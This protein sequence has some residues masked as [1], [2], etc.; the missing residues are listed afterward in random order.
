[1]AAGDGFY[2]G[3][4]LGPSTVDPGC[5]SCDTGDTGY[6]VY[7]GMALR[8]TSLGDLAVELGYIDFGH[9][10]AGGLLGSESKVDAS[11]LT[12]AAALRYHFTP[13]FG[14]VGRLGLGYV[15]GKETL[16]APLIGNSSSD[17][18][19]QPYLG[20]GVEYAINKQFAVTGAFDYTQFD[21]SKSDG[22]AYLLSVGLQY[23]F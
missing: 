15:K 7:G 6:K 1:M 9:S 11:A 17:S 22:D 3:G 4:S 18:T 16:S 12:A 23:G 5:S 20:A 21:T 2:V 14:V 19:L 8:R 10:T 13:R